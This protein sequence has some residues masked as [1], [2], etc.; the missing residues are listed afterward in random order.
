MIIHFNI[1][2]NHIII[3]MAVIIIYQYNYMINI[4]STLY[5]HDIHYII[6]IIYI[7]I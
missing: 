7:I 4:S 3:K 5:Q 1:Q 6:Y 2:H